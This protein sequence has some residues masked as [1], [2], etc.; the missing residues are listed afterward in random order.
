M[1]IELIELTDHPGIGNLALSFTD[2]HGTP[3]DTVIIAGGNGCG[4]TAILE[5]IQKT[6]E[7]DLNAHIGTVKLAIILTDE[8]AEKLAKSD[9]INAASKE[10]KRIEIEFN[11]EFDG[12]E[13]YKISWTN[14]EGDRKSQKPFVF[15]ESQV[16]SIFRTFFSEANV[17]FNASPSKSV[18][19]LV[20]DEPTQA[21]R[22]GKNLAQN[23]TQLIIDVRA[24]DSEDLSDWVNNNPNSAPS[25][26]VINQ[27][28]SRFT[29]A[30][31]H[32][33]PAKKFRGITRNEQGLNV[34]FE[35]FGRTSNINTLS[36]GEKQIVFRAGFLLKS[37]SNTKDAIIIIDEPELSLHPDWQ[38][39]IVEFYKKLLSDSSGS[40]PQILISTHSPFVVHGSATAK[41]LILEKDQKGTVQEMSKPSYPIASGSEAVQAFNL[42][43]FIKDAKQ[44]LLVLVEGESDELI[45]AQ[46]WE[47]LRPGKTMPFEARAALGMRNLNI[48]LN[49]QELFAKLGSRM[50]VGLFDFDNAYDQWNGVW[51]SKD[52]PSTLV[53][54]LESAGLIKRRNGEKAWSMLLPVPAHRSGYASKNLGGK[55]ILSIEFMF[56]DTDIPPQMID[57]IPAPLGVSNPQFKNS[58]KMNFAAHVSSLPASSFTSFKPLFEAFDKILAGSI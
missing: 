28:L 7:A 55:S 29:D 54:S 33:F 6:F 36:T 30:F 2:A 11:S 35:E 12:W 20:V 51:K 49:D 32:I 40:H 17:S 56:E 16:K 8:E 19:N 47:K 42:G 14:S 43:A 15:G 31:E 38:S 39:S 25:A 21:E 48:T 10:L 5:A 4:K 26:N 9:Q 24:A 13:K 22:S 44:P 34:E 52:K 53:S 3:F 37:L 46:A 23:I 50:V 27:R 58:Q 41:T 57:Q 1:K 18:T 45:L